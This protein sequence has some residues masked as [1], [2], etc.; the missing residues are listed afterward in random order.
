MPLIWLSLAF[1]TGILLADRFPLPAPT[2]LLLAAA[3]LALALALR[4]LRPS[5]LI[6][7]HLIPFLIAIPL[8]ALRYQAALPDLT[9]PSFIAQYNDSGKTL[10]VTGVVTAFPDRRDHYINL[11]VET[12]RIHPA[13]DFRAAPVHG[14]LLA[15]IPPQEDVHYGDRVVLRGQVLTPPEGETFSYRDYLSRQGVYSY[16]PRPGFGVL[17]RGQGNPLLQ[18]IYAIKEH[19]LATVYRL[20]PDPEASLFAGILLGVESGI[21]APVQD[22][23]KATGTT[24]IIAISGFNIT[25]I[26]GLFVTLFNRLLNPRRAALAAALGI[27]VYT[28]LVGADAA[29]VR[30]ALMGGLSL[31]ARQVGRRQHGLNS[32]AFIAALMAAFN[33]H[34]LWDVGFQLSFAATLG[35]VLYAEPFAQAF[36]RLA[37][38]VLPESRARRLTGPVGEYVLFTLAAQLTT[39]PIMAYHFG[40][41]SLSAFLANPVILPAQ[42]PVM[43]LGGLALLLGMLWLPA[44]K[45]A[46]ALAWPFVL[47]TIRV[48]EW[49]ARL[50]GGVLVLGDFGILGVILF[51]ALLFGLTL[52]W[53]RRPRWIPALKP[54][55]VTAA[56]SVLTALTWRAALSAP[57]GLLHL[58][59]LDV[60]TGDA[61]LIQTPTGRYILINGGPSPSLLADGLG[62]RLPPFNKALDWLIITNPEKEQIAALLDVIPRYPPRNVLWAGL[63]S[64]NHSA[65]YL[66]AALTEADIPITSAVRGQTLDLGEGAALR[67]LATSNRGAILLLEWNHFRALLPLGADKEGLQ[68]LDMGRA[69]GRVTVLLLA[70]NGYA[71]L[72]PPA[73]IA[74]LNPQLALL[75]VAADDPR[76]LPDAETLAALGGYS[77]LR[78]DQ[79][80]W[81][82]ITTDGQ[83]MWIE[84]EHP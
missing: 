41:I 63:P 28:L 38:R 78:T 49:F 43:T 13:D 33:P 17:E 51:Y 9:E 45:L 46:A 24:H 37:S 30:A 67:L 22:A 72:N 62:R 34:V 26:A 76:G 77:L 42:P 73:W 35:L 71:P 82:H 32:L 7:N 2:W 10:V 70:G 83:Q 20:W 61:L 12:E 19:A 57:D 69:V 79:N 53:S 48:V 64:P 11:R 84:V 36:V 16:M 47:F 60:G 31:F 29:V 14:L 55:T 5:H 65:D 75:S 81:I 52:G 59:L 3:S 66:R 15:R 80:G 50:R 40:Q 1:L 44:G 58:T 18:A 74:S 23:F 56:L 39:L 8:G 54:L 6:P 21:P 68:A 25:I 4:R 27:A